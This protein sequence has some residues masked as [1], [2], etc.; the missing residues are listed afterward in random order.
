[1]QAGGALTHGWLGVGGHKPYNHTHARTHAR[2]HTH[3]HTCL[4]GA[5]DEV[6]LIKLP[7]LR[8][9]HVGGALPLPTVCM[10]G[11]QGQGTGVRVQGL[12]LAAH[13]RCPP[14]A[15]REVKARVQGSGSNACGLGRVGGLCLAW[16]RCMQHPCRPSH[17]PRPTVQHCQQQQL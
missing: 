17:P 10:E 1:M 3:T 13:C 16:G 7:P 15:W 5:A 9:L 14:S 4:A 6:G 12:G 2:T 8:A 11:G